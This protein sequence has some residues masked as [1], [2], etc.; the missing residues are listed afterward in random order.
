MTAF[1][2]A[3]GRWAPTA[4]YDSVVALTR[5]RLWRAIV[6]AH[7]A[8]R[9]GDVI[10]D[11]GCG[12]GSLASLIGYIEPQ[13]RLIGVDP[14]PRVLAIE[15]VLLDLLSAAG[16]RDAREAD[17]VSTISGSISIYVASK[18]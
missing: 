12:T 1:T 18:P 13:A 16:F 7:L 15:G 4:V 3:A 6:V 17:V 9:P 11:V 5:E 2:P 10:V 14:D 8:P